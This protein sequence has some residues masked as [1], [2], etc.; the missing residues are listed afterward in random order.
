M[1]KVFLL[2]LAIIGFGCI[3]LPHVIAQSVSDAS[4]FEKISLPQ[5]ATRSVANENTFRQD[6]LSEFTLSS[7]RY[8]SYHIPSVNLLDSTSVNLFG[9]TQGLPFQIGDLYRP[10]GNINSNTNVN[11]TA[12]TITSAGIAGFYTTL[13]AR[14]QSRRWGTPKVP[15]YTNSRLEAKGF[16]KFG[17]FYATKTQASVISSLYDFS[18]VKPGTSAL[19]GAGIA[20]SVQSIIEIKDG[21][22]TSGGFDLYDQ[23]ANVLGTSWFFAREKVDVMQR[24]NVR[25]FYY[26]SEEKDLLEPNTR[27]NEDFGGHTYWLSMQTHDLLPEKMQRYW[28]KFIV[29][30]AGISLNNWTGPENPDHYLSYHLSI[31]PDFT[32]I[33][34]QD[35]RVGRFFTDILNGF[36]IPAPAVEVYPEFGFKL[37]FYG[38]N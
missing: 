35:S 18:N 14:E 16:D 21:R 4:S 31:A 10:D 20:L 22:V 6:Q 26:P 30:A 37:I 15:F 38:Q 12:F 32:H 33:L 13:F 7:S 5:A 25:W 34:P 19:L 2:M 3:T 9:S 28:P 23:T 17:H 36:Y 24:F 1:K 11:W 29:P 8:S 27:F